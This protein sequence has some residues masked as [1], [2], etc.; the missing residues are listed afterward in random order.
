MM[1]GS[2]PFAGTIT[3]RPIGITS[4]G[5][6]PWRPSR[7][8]RTRVKLPG[9]S[10][11]IIEPDVVSELAKRGGLELGVL[12]D[13]SPERPR[14]RDDDPDFHLAQVFM[15]SYLCA[16][17]TL[18]TPRSARSRRPPRRLVRATTTRRRATP[19]TTRRRHDDDEH[20]FDRPERNDAGSG[21]ALEQGNRLLLGV[22]A[23][24]LYPLLAASLSRYTPNQVRGKSVNIVQLEGP[25][26]SGPD[27]A[28]SSGSSSS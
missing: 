1:F 4:G 18:R 11:P 22:G 25:T 9:G 17:M 21:A 26:A 23:R 13:G 2:D 20:D 7:G 14:V 12:D 3:E 28:R 5:G 27:G 8:W 24:D 10:L 6:S 16:R 15:P 19:A